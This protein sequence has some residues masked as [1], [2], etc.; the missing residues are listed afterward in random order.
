MQVLARCLNG[1]NTAD[2]ELFIGLAQPVVSSAILRGLSR[3]SP[4]RAGLADDLIQDC[5]L[6]MCADNYRILRNFRS[7]AS[8]ALRAYLRT[9]AASVLV[10]H[11][12]RP[13]SKPWVDLEEAGGA[14]VSRDPAVEE[15][16]RRLLL[17]RVE[18][19]VAGQDE[20]SRRIF[21]LYHRQGMTPK[22][23]SSLP[24][25]GMGVSGVE[26]ALYR[27]TLAVRACLRRAGVL[28]DPSIS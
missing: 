28:P 7:A 19:C 25:I 11:F 16:E 8:N 14:L 18:K 12:R 15:L 20:R 1:G 17:G 6:K 5:F 26:T 2:W 22:S 9:I 23:I 21:W 10:D 27:L 13:G 3:A 24:G 4:A